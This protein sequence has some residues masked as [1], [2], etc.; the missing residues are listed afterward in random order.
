M[1]FTVLNKQNREGSSTTT[2]VTIPTNPPEVLTVTILIDLADME[3]LTTHVT[4]DVQVSTDNW[5]SQSTIGGG[6]WDGGPQNPKNG[7]TPT[8]S[9]TTD[10]L[11]KHTGK[12]VR[13]VLMNSPRFRVGLSVTV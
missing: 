9:F 12:Q 3:D 13:G 8:W 5:V 1:T 7:V 10:Q 11:P 2:A 6:T 4:L